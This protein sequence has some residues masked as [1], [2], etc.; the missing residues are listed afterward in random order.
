[1]EKAR[2]R[3]TERR[4]EMFWRLIWPL[5]VIVV[6]GG[7]VLFANGCGGGS[8]SGGDDGLKTDNASDQNKNNN[9]NP[10]ADD[11]N[12]PPPDNKKDD[13]PPDDSNNNPPADDKKDD[14]PPDDKKSYI[15]VATNIMNT[16]RALHA[17]TLLN[18]G[19]VLVTGGW[20]DGGFQSGAEIFHPDTGTFEIID[21]LPFHISSHTSTLL[22]D[23]RVFV[24]GMGAAIY[25]PAAKKFT[26]V[27]R[28]SAIQRVDHAATLLS[29]GKVLIMGGIDRSWIHVNLQSATLYDP[30]TGMY[31]STGSMTK[32]R[33]N[34]AA[35][36]LPDGRVLIVGGMGGGTAQYNDAE[37]YDPTTGKFT[38][39]ADKMKHIR[40]YPTATLL[41]NGKVLIVGGTFHT[42]VEIFDPATNQ[43]YLGG[44]LKAARD[45]KHTATLLSNGKVLIAGSLSSGK[46]VAS[47]EVYDPE[48]GASAGIN[49]ML[50]PRYY[51]AATLLQNGKILITGGAS[52]PNSNYLKNAELM[53]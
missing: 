42:D 1:M 53:E 49:S 28:E 29:D 32:P 23:G 19:D 25:D 22:S 24:Y 50:S 16:A 37:I 36:L 27:P 39:V 9:N 31:L 11:N 12:N 41:P 13:P 18:N 33:N 3:R 40:M 46:V 43:F 17:A 14:P 5:V 38:I 34:H 44:S 52:S 48:I 10:P 20:N 4:S 35:V 6:F 45:V 30:S 8:S 51:H 15:F 21:A 47:A 26:S 2:D 7:A